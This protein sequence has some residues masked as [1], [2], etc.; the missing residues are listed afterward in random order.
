MRLTIAPSGHRAGESH[1]KAK[2]S[3]NDVRLIREL[4]E[5]HGLGYGTIAKKFDSSRST[6]IS[7]CN[8]R[9]RI[10]VI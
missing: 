6:I 5:N 2:L 9:C 1:P 10:Y 3:D 8:Y 7:I 4:H